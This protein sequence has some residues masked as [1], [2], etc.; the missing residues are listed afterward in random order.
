MSLTDDLFAQYVSGGSY[1]LVGGGRPV[2]WSVG[3]SVGLRFS[4]ESY[5]RFPEGHSYNVH[6]VVVSNWTSFR[7]NIKYFIFNINAKSIGENK[8]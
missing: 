3:R 7:F 2:G 4:G 1:R 8:I 5:P 6:C